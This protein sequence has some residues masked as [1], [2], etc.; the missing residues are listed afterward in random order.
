MSSPRLKELW[1]AIQARIDTPDALKIMKVGRTFRVTEN[2]ADF[3]GPEGTIWGLQVLKPITTLWPTVEISDEFRPVAFHIASYMNSVGGAD[4]TDPLE[5]L[6][7]IVYQQLH[8]WTP[9]A[10]MFQRVL[11]SFMITR[12]RPPQTMPEWDADRNL[13][14]LSSDY[15]T[16]AAPK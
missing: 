15:K 10:N 4:V 1:P 8:Q 13:W 6:Q 11:M 5:K 2:F 9:P 3:R 14:M 16:E 12:Q 7:D